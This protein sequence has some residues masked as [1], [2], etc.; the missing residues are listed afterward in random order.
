MAIELGAAYI[1]ILPSTSKL[2]PAI[3]AELQKA[4]IEAGRG[5]AQSGDAFGRRFSASLSKW[6]KRGLLAGASGVGLLGAAGLKTASD[7]EQSQIGFET[8]LGSAKKANDFL[9]LITKTAAHTPFQLKGLTQASQKMLAFGFNVKD[10]IPDLTILGDAAAGLGIGAEGVDR[11]VIALG[12]IKAK[13]RVQGDEILQLTEAGIPAMKILQ[14]ELGLTAD[15]YQDLQRKGKITAEDAIPALLKGIK[16]GTKGAA[17]ETA[18]FGGLMEKQST[19]LAGLFSTLK[20]T[21]LVGTAKAIKP[22]IPMLKDGLASAIK[23]SGPA[24]ESAGKGLASFVKGAQDGTGA[25]GEFADTVRDIWSIVKPVSKATISLAQSFNGLPGGAKKVLLLAGAALILQR[26]FGD[27]LPNFQNYS[28]EAL[29]ATGKT[30]AMKGALVGAG[31]ALGALASSAGGA[32]T[33]VG[34]LATVGAGLATGAAFG[35]PWGAVIGGATS[36]LGVLAT[37]SGKAAEKQQALRDGA[38][39]VAD[40]LNQQTGALTKYTRAQAARELADSGALTAANAMGISTKDVLAATLGSTPALYRV[41]AA[42]E[43]W[44]NKLAKSGKYTEK[45]EGQLVTLRKAIGATSSSIADQRNKIDQVN[46]AMGRGKDKTVKY[47]VQ[48][49]GLSAALQNLIALVNVVDRAKERS[50]SA[51]SAIGQNA[52]GTNNWRGGLTWVGE[53]G[54]ELVNLQ[55]GAQVIPNHKVSSVG[56]EIASSTSVATAA[57]SKS[58]TASPFPKRLTLQIGGKEFDA[59]VGDLAGD[60]YSG[61]AAFAGTTRRMT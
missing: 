32:D 44:A 57:T 13:G 39:R 26:R 9:A 56:R 40:T 47:S 43:A 3:R 31:A 15:E 10:V 14:N 20:D 61:E 27:S 51:R 2:A 19:S 53:K 5:G 41:S 42:S 17:G 54:P 49:P 34:Q 52:K 18:K 30:V 28:K 29:V 4:G 37:N 36:L 23:E 7:L 16:N 45:Q 38:Q 21:V 59:Y 48:T 1:S 22:L 35:G 8:M 60:T 11:L 46:E 12:Q 25:G 55:K 50:L 33:E 58:T 24:L 6:T